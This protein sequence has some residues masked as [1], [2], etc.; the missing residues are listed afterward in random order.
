VFDHL[1]PA[2]PSECFAFPD[3]R[4]L[5]GCISDTWVDLDRLLTR[6]KTTII[7][8]STPV[9]E[10]SLVDYMYLL[11]TV[12]R[13]SRFISPRYTRERAAVCRVAE[14]MLLSGIVTQ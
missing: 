9:S 7:W 1:Q 11:Q 12:Y 10:C 8:T 4:H 6:R 13:R 5:S 14:T 2:R 3:D